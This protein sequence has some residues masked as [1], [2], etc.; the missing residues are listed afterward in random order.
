MRGH[1]FHYSSLSL[2]RP[3][4]YGCMLADAQG[5]HQGR[6]GLIKDNAI[7][8][9]THLHFASNPG[10]AGSFLHAVKAKIGSFK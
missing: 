5:N 1:E 10:L 3:P 7:G 2:P 8:L 4:V 9:Y 6:D